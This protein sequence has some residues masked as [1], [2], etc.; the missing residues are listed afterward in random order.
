MKNKL[1]LLYLP[2]LA[3]AHF[4]CEE[5]MIIVPDVNVGDRRVLV[6]ELTGVACTNC[7]DGAREL[8]NLQATYGKENLIVVSIHSGDY[9]TPLPSS[10]VDF[11]SAESDA[12]ATYIGEE[13]GYPTGAINR[14]LLPGNA[15]LFLV[16][17]LWKPTISSEFNRDYGLGMFLISNFDVTTRRLDIQVNLSPEQTLEGENRLTVLITQDSIIDTQIDNGVTQTDYVHRHVLRDVVTRPD[18]DPLTEPLTAGGLVIRN[19]A[20]TIPEDW[21][22]RHL[23]VVAYVHHGGLPDK[24]VLQ[25]VERHVID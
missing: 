14:Y 21:E 2:L 11:R 24:E 4:S 6:E 16:R 18:G 19:Y 5:K 12:L 8:A 20:V 9:T 25:V 3:L 13:E 22:D 23:S 7:P 10:R 17:P 15:T 1:A